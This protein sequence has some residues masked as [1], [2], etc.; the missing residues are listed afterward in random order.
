MIRLRTPRLALRDFVDA[1]AEFVYEII[2]SKEGVPSFPR[3]YSRSEA[4]VWIEKARALQAEY[5]AAFWMAVRECDQTPIGFYG[6]VVQRIDGE[7][8]HEVG[9]YTHQKFRGQG[10]AREAATACIGWAFDHFR[11]D[12]IGALILPNNEA[13][14]AVADSVGMTPVRTVEHAGHSHVAYTVR[15][16]AFRLIA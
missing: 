9:W 2:G 14:L 7:P 11:V 10:Y 15:R 16:E 1:D 8:F 3:T 6:P 4:D 5:G 12:S 13:S